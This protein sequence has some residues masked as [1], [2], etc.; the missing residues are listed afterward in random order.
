MN[1][2]EFISF[3]ISIV[4]F[5]FDQERAHRTPIAGNYRSHKKGSSTAI[6]YCINSRSCGRQSE[7]IRLP[8]RPTKMESRKSPNAWLVTK[9][10]TYHQKLDYCTRLY[11]PGY[12]AHHMNKNNRQMNDGGKGKP[13]NKLQREDKKKINI[14]SYKK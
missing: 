12:C 13:I 7:S 14:Y 8:R 2:N 11:K 4:G 9:Y 6:F 10:C 5:E 3:L 1:H